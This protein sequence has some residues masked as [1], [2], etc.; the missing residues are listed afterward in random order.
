MLSTS[1]LGVSFGMEHTFEARCSFV[2]E[3][4]PLVWWVF[5]S[6][7]DC[8]PIELFLIPASAT[9]LMYQRSW[10]VLSCLWDGAYKISHAAN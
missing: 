3:R 10:Y 1:W 7:L 2:V 8:G 5:G 6:I 4:L 9:Q